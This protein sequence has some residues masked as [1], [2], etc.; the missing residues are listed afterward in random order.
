MDVFISWK[1]IGKNNLER[2][3]SD[4][5]EVNFLTEKEESQSAEVCIVMPNFFND[6]DLGAY[7]KLKFVQL[8]MAGYDKFEMD[9][10]KRLAITVANAQDIF[11][12]PVAEDALT[13][14]FVLNRN[15]RHYA[16]RMKEKAWTP[17]RE[18]PE[19]TGSTV[20][21]LGTGSIGKELAKRLKGFSTKILGYA[22]T[23]RIIPDFDQIL[24]GDEGLETLLSESDYVILALPLTKDTHHLI[25]ARKLALL[26][27]T[28]L[29]I[30]VARG[31]IVDQEALIEVLKAG[32]IRGAGLDVT[33]PEPLP[34]S[35]E[36]WNLPNVYLTPHNASSSPYMQDRLAKLTRE[37]L[38]RYLD[39]KKLLYVI[40]E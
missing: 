32:K 28:A 14:I 29:L 40:S 24:T 25:D 31:E 16:E 39:K 7:R 3:R 19:L 26:K 21:I 4:F 30:N 2:L 12:I 18:E 33:T 11:S 5:P 8:L 37:N 38:R 15:V 22:R 13:K 20:G 9:S 10:A 34:T 6:K 23:D 27:P 1:A 36:L 35:S 17:I